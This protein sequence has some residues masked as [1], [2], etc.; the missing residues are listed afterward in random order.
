MVLHVAGL[1]EEA[2]PDAL[3]LGTSCKQALVEHVRT[4]FCQEHQDRSA[5]SAMTDI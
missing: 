5:T 1:S 4:T 2:G 3:R